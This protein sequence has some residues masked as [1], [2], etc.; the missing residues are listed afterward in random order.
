MNSKIDSSR[1]Q[2]KFYENHLENNCFFI[3]HTYV[4]IDSFGYFMYFWKF[5]REIWLYEVHNIHTYVS[6]D[7]IF[8]HFCD[9]SKFIL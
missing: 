6:D 3:L 2:R 1:F 5:S 4:R 8:I 9:Q 7:I